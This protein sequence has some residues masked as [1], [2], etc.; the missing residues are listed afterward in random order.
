MIAGLEEVTSGAT[1]IGERDEILESA[2]EDG[3]L[4]AGHAFCA[5]RVDAVD[6]ACSRYF[7][8]APDARLDGVRQG[9]LVGA[10]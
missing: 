8:A 2:S 1:R 4:P 10:R 5:A 6:P 9:P 3:L 7:D